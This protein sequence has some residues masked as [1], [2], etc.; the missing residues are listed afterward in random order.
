MREWANDAPDRDAFTDYRGAQ[1]SWSVTYDAAEYVAL[2]GTYG[3][4]LTLEADVR[5]P[6]LDA[7]GALIDRNGGT[8]ELPYTTH[9]LVARAASAA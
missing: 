4:H 3:D 6:L 9:L 2:L 7:I 1:F 8:I 5:E